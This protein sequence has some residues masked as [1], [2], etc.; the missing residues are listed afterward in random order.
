MLEP[1][2]R[3]S[4]GTKIIRGPIQTYGEYYVSLP[5]R[6][7]IQHDPRNDSG[8]ELMT[9][10]RVHPEL[11]QQIYFPALAIENEAGEPRQANTAELQIIEQMC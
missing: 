9:K 6:P 3:C 5:K 7:C 8:A 4:A 1:R 10:L 2:F 11:K